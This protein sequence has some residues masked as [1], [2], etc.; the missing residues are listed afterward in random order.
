[1]ETLQEMREA[2]RDFIEE[3]IAQDLDE[4]RLA[5]LKAAGKWKGIRKISKAAARTA[6]KVEPK[7]ILMHTSRKAAG[8]S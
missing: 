8:L 3:T 1:M 5:A 2:L 7:N 4:G 6:K